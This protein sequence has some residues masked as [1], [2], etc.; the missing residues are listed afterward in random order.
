MPSA[1]TAT[2]SEVAHPPSSDLSGTA[3][4]R[5]G[6]AAHVKIDDQVSGDPEYR[7]ELQ[8][9]RRAACGLDDPVMDTIEFVSLGSYCATGLALQSLGLRQSSYP[10]DWVRSPVVGVIQCLDTRF[11]DFLTYTTVTSTGGHQVYASSAWG[12]SFWHHDPTSTEVLQDMTRRA[13]RLLGFQQGQAQK[14]R[15]FVRA[16]NSTSELDDIPRLY[17]TLQTCFPGVWFRLLVLVDMQPVAAPMRVQSWEHMG[18]MIHAIKEDVWKSAIMGGPEDVRNHMRKVTHAYGDAIAYAARRWA[19]LQTPPIPVRTVRN[20]EALHSVLTCFDGGNPASES[21][22]PKRLH[23]HTLQLLDDD[24]AAT[25][26]NVGVVDPATAA[27]STQAQDRF[28][29]VQLPDEIR[30]GDTLNTQAFGMSIRLQIP[31]G[32]QGGQYVQLR[33]AQGVVSFALAAATISTAAAVLSTA[34]AVAASPAAAGARARESDLAP[35]A[36][37]P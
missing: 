30:P 19:G 6:I 28:A 11:R 3:T 2:R 33:F 13:V 12:G 23:G 9:Q 22:F 4:G 16:V 34:T 14:P 21:F 1:D 35:E 32:A 27:A 18:I 15:I 8:A 20:V 10:F 26:L 29:Q 37:R 5:A 25:P 17:T 36:R 24:A 31:D 7:R